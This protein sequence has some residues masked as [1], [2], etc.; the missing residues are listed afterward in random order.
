MPYCFCIDCN[1]L[2]NSG[3]LSKSSV[4]YLNAELLII[5]SAVCSNLSFGKA[6]LIELDNI[7]LAFIVKA[8][9]NASF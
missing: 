7:S 1:T 9:N 6:I 2:P 3:E 5:S 8:A 4:N